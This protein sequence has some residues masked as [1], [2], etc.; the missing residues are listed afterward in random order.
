MVQ[1]SGNSI[2]ILA[3]TIGDYMSDHIGAYIKHDDIGL[4]PLGQG[5]LS[6]ST[7]VAKDLFDVAGHV[8]GAGSPDW[9]ASHGEAKMTA[10]SVTKLLK[11]GAKMVAKAQTDEMAFSI[12]GQNAHYGT[13]KNVNAPG[14]IP[15]GSSSG[16]AA[17]VAGGLV[18]FALGS[19][20]G[21]SV[22][23]PASFCG[24]FGIRTTQGRVPVDGIHPLA[25]CFDTVGWFSRNSELF[26]VIGQVLLPDFSPAPKLGR[27]L[28]AKD[29]FSY[30]NDGDREVLRLVVDK[31]SNHFNGQ[32]EINVSDDGPDKWVPHFRTLQM[33]DVW[34][35]HGDW[36]KRYKPNFGPG[37]AERFA[38]AATIVADDVRAS[39]LKQNEI[40]RHIS[41]L[42]KTGDILCL[43]TTPGIAPLLETPEPTLDHFRSRVMALT[44]V[45]GLSGCPQIN[46]P[47]IYVDN[48]PLGLSLMAAPGHDEA[49]LNLAAII[50]PQH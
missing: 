9:L 38:M 19:D 21:G 25:P 33:A 29:C 40:Y 10:S 24:I 26:Q 12:T 16:S 31:I 6:G 42:L 23:V 3:E 18:D 22:R 37:V 34:K 7:F 47:S 44:C 5:P 48:C 8:T 4:L 13:P 43:P 1:C 45:A 30:L 14:R 32:E 2:R 11:A 36:V 41:S 49:L 20:T 35:T 17:A 46:L 28:I 15:G 39:R 50:A 27:L